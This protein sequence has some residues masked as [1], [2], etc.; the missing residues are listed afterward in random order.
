MRGNLII[1]RESSFEILIILVPIMYLD[2]T[3]KLEFSTI[4]ANQ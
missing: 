1:Y 4:N 3:D 2:R